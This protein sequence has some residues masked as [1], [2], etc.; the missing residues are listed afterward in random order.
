MLLAIRL[1]EGDRESL[2]KFYSFT[3]IHR[4]NSLT[5]KKTSKKETFSHDRIF[6]TRHRDPKGQKENN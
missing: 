3:A 6:H 2:F 1:Q 4:R 5:N